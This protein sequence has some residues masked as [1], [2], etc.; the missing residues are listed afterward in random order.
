[1]NIIILGGGI[2]GLL[3]AYALRRKKPTIIEASAKLGGNFTAGGLKYIHDT[4]DIRQLLKSLGIVFEPYKPRGAIFLEGSVCSH[5]DTLAQMDKLH[6]Y[7]IQFRH[8]TKTRA[9]EVGFREDC[10]NDPLG[11]HAALRCDHQ[12]LLRR[13]EERVREAG[14]EVRLGSKVERIDTIQGD[15]RRGIHL[16]E[17]LS[18]VA[19]GYDVLVPTLPLGLLSKLAIWADLPACEATKLAIFEMELPIYVRP[20]WDYMYTPDAKWITRLVQPEPHTVMAEVPWYLPQYD[21]QDPH[22]TTTDAI[23]EVMDIMRSTF[24][25]EGVC[26]GARLIPGHLRPLDRPPVWPVG[27]YPLGRFAQWDSRA[28]ADKVYARALSIAESLPA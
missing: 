27:W 19:M 16:R 12:E 1:M 21:H 23:P 11:N 5:P 20:S 25:L 2:A 17:G 24:G 22:L 13:L 9:S 15:G 6:R 7:Q 14:C 10:M 8:W 3:G 18:E 28:T 26:T 4:P